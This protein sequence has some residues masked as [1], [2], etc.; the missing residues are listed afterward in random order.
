MARR[1]RI[2][3]V[4]AAAATLL[5]LDGCIIEETIE[6]GGGK[7]AKD[8]PQAIKFAD[9]AFETCVRDALGNFNPQLFPADVAALTHLSCRDRQIASIAGIEKLAGLI[10]L[11][12]WE[13]EVSD[14]GP[15]AKLTG[16]V[17][18]QLGN[19]LIADLGPL[20]GLTNLRRLGLS[21]NQLADLGPLAALTSLEWLNLDV[22]HITDIAPLAGLAGLRWLTI[23]HNP[24]GAPPALDGLR[25]NGCDVYAE[26]PDGQ[27]DWPG[28]QAIERVLAPA[29]EAR[30]PGADVRRRGRLVPQ[31]AAHGAVALTYELD[32]RAFDVIEEYSGRIT[33]EANEYVYHQ[34]GERI[35]IGTVDGP[36]AGLCSGRHAD[37]CE[38]SIG[39]KGPARGHA[40]D[41]LPGVDGP[42][43]SANLALGSLSRRLRDR[44]AGTHALGAD[45][46]F[47]VNLELLPFVLASP[48]QE[49]AGSCLFMATTGA[50]EV[51]MSQH[52]P[53]EA[54]HNGGDTDLSERFL[55]NAADYVPAGAIRYFLT[56]TIYTYNA[57]GGSLLDRDYPFAAGYV[58]ETA[59]GNVV[60]AKPSD[61]G[62]Y[63]SCSYS[64]F[65][66]L[67]EG[68]QNK[69]TPTPPV[70]RTSIFVEPN[71]DDNSWWQVALMDDSTIEKIKYE[72]R[73]K[74][75]P[76]IIVYNHYLYWHADI[77][78]GYDD[79]A[80]RNGCPM[81][82]SSIAEYKK[83]GM[84]QYADAIEAHKAA[85][86][87]CTNQGIFY[88]RDSIYPGTAEEATYTYG[89][90]YSYQE[91]YSQRIIEREYDWVRYLS[92]HAFT[93]HRR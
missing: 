1:L 61:D 75:A 14:V 79:N 86:G 85:L 28:S 63:F 18:L 49:D 12:L 30:S 87:G 89:G 90:G 77:I 67:P 57:F 81:V 73:T 37:A 68:W 80:P 16:L 5:L 10:G 54:V 33:R 59:G 60:K 69:L 72:L 62:A 76:V 39:I 36:G 78:V 29:W 13:N 44:A 82:E 11:S 65:D 31:L 92:N 45:A 17:D 56:D 66:E 4:L 22:N 64:W 47:P 26:F 3:A 50:T 48:N 8:E 93:V 55:M 74:Q 38:L 58:K 40:P 46:F 21:I 42:V 32:G 9:A 25:A 53:I 41:A 91:K 23:E 84:T 7:K 88:V 19:N 83:K 27:H 52:A 70:E 35:V 6:E 34:G 24:I 2:R 20:A 71:R 15:L 51:L 43:V